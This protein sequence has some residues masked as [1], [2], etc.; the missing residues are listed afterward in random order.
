MKYL[1]LLVGFA[2]VCTASSCPIIQYTAIHGSYNASKPALGSL[3][4]SLASKVP[5]GQA[6]YRL[7]V[8]RSDVATV[9]SMGHSGEEF[10]TYVPLKF[11]D[12]KVRMIKPVAKN[13]G[14]RNGAK[15]KSSPKLQLLFKLLDS[16]EVGIVTCGAS[17]SKCPV[18]L[19]QSTVTDGYHK[20]P[21]N[22]ASTPKPGHG[23]KLSG[24]AD[25]PA[26]YC[27]A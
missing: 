7:S 24:T 18:H 26:D 2:A 15:G 8:Q 6:F 13:T 19:Y 1:L 14:C 21:T 25:C 10:K 20:E 23:R 11:E 22:S 12:D 17:Q 5:A 27:A 4:D 3:D 9:C 16:A